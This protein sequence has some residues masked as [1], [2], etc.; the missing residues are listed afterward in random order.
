MRKTATLAVCVMALMALGTAAT[1]TWTVNSTTDLEAGTLTNTTVNTSTDSVVLDQVSGANN[2]SAYMTSGTYLSGWHDWGNTGNLT[3]FTTTDTVPPNTSLTYEIRSSS[4]GTAGTASD[5]Y[6]DYAQVPDDQYVQF[7]AMY[8][9]T[10]NQT[11]PETDSVTVE[12]N[13]AESDTLDVTLTTTPDATTTDDTPEFAGDVSSSGTVEYR[14]DGGSWQ[15]V[16]TGCDQFSFETGSLSSGSHTVDVRASTWWGASDTASDSFDVADGSEFTFKPATT[17]TYRDSAIPID[18]DSSVWDQ[19]DEDFNNVDFNFTLVGPETFDISNR[20]ENGICELEGNSEWPIPGE[21]DYYCGTEVP[22]DA[23][24]GDYKLKVEWELNGQ[25]SGWVDPSTGQLVSQSEAGTISIS[26]AGEWMSDRSSHGGHLQDDS[27]VGYNTG[28]DKDSSSEDGAIYTCPDSTMRVTNIGSITVQC[29]NGA[30]GGSSTPGV[31]G[32]VRRG[33]TGG[34]Q[35]KNSNNG[36]FGGGCSIDDSVS[37]DLLTGSRSSDGYNP[38]CNLGWTMDGSNSNFDVHTFSSAGTY[39]VDLAYINAISDSPDFLC[40]ADPNNNQCDVGSMSGDQHGWEHLTQKTIKV[41]NPELSETGSSLSNVIRDGQW[42]RRDDYN[43]SMSL[44]WTLEN[45]GVG[46]VS[47]DD[48]SIQCPDGMNCDKPSVSVVPE[49]DTVTLDFSVDSPDGVRG[50]GQ[51]QITIT[52]SDD[53]GLDCIGQHTLT[54]TFQVDERGP[55]TS[56]SGVSGDFE[57]Y[58]ATSPHEKWYTEKPVDVSLACSDQGIGCDT[59]E[60]CTGSASCAPDQTPPASVGQ[61][62]VNN[63]RHQGVDQLGNTGNIGSTAV[64][65]DTEPPTVECQDCIQPGRAETGQ[66]ILM[67]ADIS[68]AGIGVDRASY[69]SDEQCS[70]TF[71]SGTGNTSCTYSSSERTSSEVW[72]RTFDRLGRRTVAQ[73][74]SFEVLLPDGAFC[75]ADD[76]CLSGQCTENTCEPERVPPEVIIQ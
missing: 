27:S 69:C 10:D 33:G 71:C 56:V 31:V 38:G 15:L 36:M 3:G 13:V 11:T 21:S 51:Y 1:Q 58:N 22:G 57:W 63:V 66:D 34:E 76:Q 73:I 32:F 2:T 37:W 28:F 40:P 12:A 39:A 23:T 75:S 62:G 61:E 64:R 41:V 60:W 49:G 50:L 52:Y 4:D 45:T 17:S 8:G 53:H 20:F 24:Y 19:G 18:P 70:Q 47:I 16:C 7:R 48:I 5:W 29:T 9:T 55:S 65:I 46:D 74:G 6:S 44:T 14:V 43:S 72:V 59:T 35:I 68:D 26:E 67:S 54:K 30:T 42:I 25:H